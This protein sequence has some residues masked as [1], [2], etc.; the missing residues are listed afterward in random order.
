LG[1]LEKPLA[2]ITEADFAQ[3]ICQRASEHQTLDYKSEAYGRKDSDVWE[4]LKDISAMA[5]ASGGDIVL[6][7]GEDPSEPGVPLTI[8]AVEDGEEEALRIQQVCLDCLQDRIDGLSVRAIRLSTD[9]HVLIIRIP[10]SERQPHMVVRQGRRDFYTRHDT[11]NVT[12]SLTEMRD[13]F[14]QGPDIRWKLEDLRRERT[15]F[16]IN[17]ILPASHPLNEWRVD[18]FEPGHVHFRKLSA[19]QIVTVPLRWIREVRYDSLKRFLVV[20]LEDARMQWTH[21]NLRWQCLQPRPVPTSPG[22]FG[23][24]VG[25]TDPARVP[26]M[27]KLQARGYELAWDWDHRVAHHEGNGWEV[28]Y[29]DDGLFVYVQDRL[30]KQILMGRSALRGGEPR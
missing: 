10:R 22:G 25:G 4:M 20:E 2:E 6:G 23:K 1:F 14:R 9:R 28:I 7:V 18:D 12:M 19:G 27:P 8:I 16:R 26:L 17:P 29:D 5:N 11:V 3:R 13:T 15:Q 21:P 30:T 24:A